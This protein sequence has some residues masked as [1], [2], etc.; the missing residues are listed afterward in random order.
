MGIPLLAGKK[1]LHCSL[2]Q[3]NLSFCAFKHNLFTV[4]G[5]K[6]RS[7]RSV[8][9]TGQ[10]ILNIKHSTGTFACLA[11]RGRGPSLGRQIHRARLR[12]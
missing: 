3:Y 6:E 8:G 11:Y 7:V 12:V 5:L 4:P 10:M 1:R 2:F 9:P